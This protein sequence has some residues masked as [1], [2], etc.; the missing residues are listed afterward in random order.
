[1]RGIALLSFPLMTALFVVADEFL[2]LVF[3]PPWEGST[4][5]LRVL[6]LVG[7]MQSIGTTTGWIYRA[8]GRADWQFRF[9]IVAG[10][11]ALVAFG[12]GVR[13]GILGVATAYAVRNLALTYFNFAIP[14]RLIGLRYR[15]VVA[16]VAGILACAL[17][18]AA[19]LG[20]LDAALPA[21]PRSLVALAAKLS[22]AGCVYLGLAALFRLR[23]LAEVADL[24]GETLGPARGRSRPLG[25]PR[26]AATRSP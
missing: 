13:F 4:D 9:G 2:V 10:V 24:A 21:G 22:F 20:V 1:M 25:L 16:S 5:V 23:A 15:D 8:H 17:A 14:G 19:A 3:G 11:T 26:S 18:S 12:I 6:C 7:L